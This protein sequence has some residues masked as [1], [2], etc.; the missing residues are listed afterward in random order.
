[1]RVV[2]KKAAAEPTANERRLMPLLRTSTMPTLVAA[3]SVC[4]GLAAATAEPAADRWVSPAEFYGEPQ[5][6]GGTKERL[7]APAA[8]AGKKPHIWMLLFDDYGWADAGWHRDTIGP[9]GVHIPADPEV[10]TPNL[11]QMVKEGIELDRA[12]VYKYCSPT[13][14]ALQS[15]RN[16]YHVNPLNA[17]PNIANHSD[18][19]SGF[20]AIPRNMTGIATKLSAAGYLTHSFGKWDAGM[21]TPGEQTP[22]L[23]PF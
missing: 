15:G 13:R 6:N 14:S 23:A 7:I 22:F 9:G 21:A 11:N 5:H 4:A 18:P 8:G 10:V 2:K 20:A 17:A 16:P 3:L 1:M 19:V 12:Y